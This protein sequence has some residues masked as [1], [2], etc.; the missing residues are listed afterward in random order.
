MDP[1]DPDR[2]TSGKAKNPGRVAWGKKLAALAK[3]HKKEK[4]EERAREAEDA[5]AVQRKGP[6]SLGAWLAVGSLVI[7]IAA[8]YYQRK[9]SLGAGV[10]PQHHRSPQ[11]RDAWQNS[12]QRPRPKT[13][14]LCRKSSKCSDPRAGGT[15]PYR[16]LAP[17]G[18]SPP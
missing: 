15:D 17:P 4:A 8:L 5:H 16:R 7:G 2:V 3:A 14:L 9:A 6:T 18:N 12:S 10:D 13:N 1:E 11:L